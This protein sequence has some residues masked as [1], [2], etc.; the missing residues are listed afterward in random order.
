MTSEPEY[1]I[2]FLPTLETPTRPGTPEDVSLQFDT[3]L[4]R[5]SMVISQ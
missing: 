3:P 5:M 1:N 2:T 4:E